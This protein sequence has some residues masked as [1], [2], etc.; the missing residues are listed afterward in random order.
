MDYDWEKNCQRGK[1]ILI[2]NHRLQVTN[3]I[4][5]IENICGRVSPKTG[6]GAEYQFKSTM[7]E[8]LN[9]ENYKNGEMNENYL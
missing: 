1:E 5:F 4:C 3:M 7:C 2:T 6:N 8:S 9:S